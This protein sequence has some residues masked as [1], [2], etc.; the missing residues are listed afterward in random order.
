MQEVII[1]VYWRSFALF[2]FSFAF[3]AF[4]ELLEWW[5]ALATGEKAEVFLGAQG[6]VWDTQSD[7]A[8][9]LLGS[10]IG[11]LTL[12]KQHDRQLERIKIT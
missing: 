1:C 10:I 3:S 9:A 5:V 7:M 4:C 8:M 6:Y 2:A 12:S 11:L